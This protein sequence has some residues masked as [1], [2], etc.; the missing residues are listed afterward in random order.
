MAFDL[1]PSLFCAIITIEHVYHS[2]AR[3]RTRGEF[4]GFIHDKLDIKLLILYLLN[5]AVAPIDFATLTDL[6]MC[7]PGVEY[8]DFA[9]AVSELVQS[10][11]I[12]FQDNLY[13]ITEKGR[14]N[15]SDC[16]S[17]LS[18]VIR[19]RCDSNLAPINAALQRS[20]QIRSEI[21]ELGP[22]SFVLRLAMDD[23]S[24]NLLSLSLSAVSRTQCE[25]M[26]N[27][28]TS[29]AESFYHTVLHTLLSSDT[30]SKT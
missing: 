12:Q 21:E 15:S 18:P 23:D 27:Y 11:H 5:K 14:R 17:S 10:S 7:D 20:A 25:Q 26:A 2:H 13:S 29:N 4:M 16:E 19:R 3:L 24:G 9:E 1:F 6:S 22:A 8:F 30:P 28:F